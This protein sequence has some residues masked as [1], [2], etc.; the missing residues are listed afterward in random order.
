[1]HL[2]I[3]ADAPPKCKAPL[4]D[5]LLV[6]MWIEACA[7]PTWVGTCPLTWVIFVQSGVTRCWSDLVTCKRPKRS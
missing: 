1:M 2:A 5:P 7:G 6:M 3:V 4:A